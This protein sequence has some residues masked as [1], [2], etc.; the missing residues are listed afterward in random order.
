MLIEKI[1]ERFHK[2]YT[3]VDSGCWEWN[4][5][6]NPKGYGYFQV[7]SEGLAHRASYR[8]H[9]L[10]CPRG[11]VV[12]HSCDNPPC[13]NPDHLSLGTIKDNNQDRHFKGRTV[14]PNHN[15]FKTH[16][17]RGHEFTE[18]N[19]YIKSKGRRECRTCMKLRRDGEI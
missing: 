14:T 2:N 15:S 5:S 11:K 10:N 17:K 16:C 7:L 9:N 19:T 13:V 1:I 3:K 6:R 8:L 4:K 18:E 12:M